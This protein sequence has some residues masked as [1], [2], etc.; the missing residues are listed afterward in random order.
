VTRSIEDK[1]AEVAR[2]GLCA[3]CAFSQL[4]GS[5]KASGSRFYR[6]KRADDDPGYMKYPP[7]PVIGCEGHSPSTPAD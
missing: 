4:Q 2:V 1:R 3:T 6:C 5:T 7:T